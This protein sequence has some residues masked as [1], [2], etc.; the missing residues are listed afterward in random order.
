MKQLNSIKNKAVKKRSLIL[1]FLIGIFTVGTSLVQFQPDGVLP[2]LSENNPK[3]TSIQSSI[4]GN[5][6]YT[7]VDPISINEASDWTDLT[8]ITG[9][10]TEFDP[11]I[12]ENIEIIG[13]DN[14]F[15][16]SITSKG[17]SIGYNAWFRIQ[18]CKISGFHAAIYC[19]TIAA[20]CQHNIT[21]NEIDQCGIGIY[22]IG[23]YYRIARN[24]ISECH[25]KPEHRPFLLDYGEPDNIPIHGGAGIYTSFTSGLQWVEENTVSK[26]DVGIALGHLTVVRNNHLEDCGFIFDRSHLLSMEV[27]GNTV[28]DLPLGFFTPN[29]YSTEEHEFLILDG[30]DQQYGQ[31]IVAM[32]ENVILKNLL[33][34][35]SSLG[36]SLMLNYNLTLSNVTVENCILGMYLWD[37]GPFVPDEGETEFI[38]TNELNFRDCE[39]GVQ[40]NVRRSESNKLIYN[41]SLAFQS[42]SGNKYDLYLGPDAII[43]ISITVPKSTSLFFDFYIPFRLSV[44]Y[45][46][47][48]YEQVENVTSH[49]IDPYQNYPY[50]AIEVNL[51]DLGTYEFLGELLLI[52]DSEVIDY[53][54]YHNFTI[55][56]KQFERIKLPGFDS[57]IIIGVSC[58]SV[59]IVLIFTPISRKRES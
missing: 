9:N 41:V 18:N 47:K 39:I 57:W 25:A 20:D 56:A 36:I 38:E 19:I 55:I 31:I 30:N 32:C 34:R 2:L 23:P 24:Q 7:T 58:F 51:N 13:Q 43:G 49:I 52:E 59:G 50:D 48:P 27:Q 4:S 29:T 54:S 46:G 37:T 8:F 15:E 16:D 14:M 10:G 17:I 40:I 33:I 42:F 44:L 35:N 26:C 28:N 11:Y 22:T 12:I 5:I 6:Q 45:E 3:T 53:I 21:D 1:L